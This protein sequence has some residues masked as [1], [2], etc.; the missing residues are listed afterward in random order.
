MPGK[1]QYITPKKSMNV[2]ALPLP[3]HRISSVT[4]LNTPIQVLGQ[5]AGL[6]V[7]TC[8]APSISVS[9]YQVVRPNYAKLLVSETKRG[10]S[11]YSFSLV[12]PPCNLDSESICSMSPLKKRSSCGFLR[13]ISLEYCR[14]SSTFHPSPLFDRK[15]V[16]SIFFLSRAFSIQDR[17]SALK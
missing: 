8:S 13:V 12:S 1:S 16:L 5:P 10:A 6:G 9:Y 7:S 17:L 15:F 2:E 4:T 3:I 11:R 14:M